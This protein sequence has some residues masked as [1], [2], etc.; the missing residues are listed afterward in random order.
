MARTVNLKR[1]RVLFY[2]GLV[3]LLVGGPGLTAGTYAH[4]SFRVPVLGSAFDAFGWVN[5][6]A[7]VLGIIFL[8]LGIVFLVLGL[9][10]GVLSASELAD[11]K[12]G[13]S[14]T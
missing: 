5:Q 7:L 1:D 12:A 3:L 9:R 13:R 14:R 8:L 4:D 10:G 11:L 2:L 6:T